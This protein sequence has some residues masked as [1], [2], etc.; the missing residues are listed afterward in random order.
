MVETGQV[1][2]GLWHKSLRNCLSIDNNAPA[3]DLEFFCFDDLL[4]NLT[5]KQILMFLLFSENFVCLLSEF[6]MYE[7]PKISDEGSNVDLVQFL[8]IGLA[9]TFKMNR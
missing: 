9:N 8:Y 1:T 5:D 3:K 2:I 6:I 4:P 7:G